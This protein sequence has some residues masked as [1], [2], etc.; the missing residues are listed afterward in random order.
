MAGLAPLVGEVLGVGR[1]RIE[2][3]TRHSVRIG[4]VIDFEINDV[5]PLDVETGR[6]VRFDGTFH[7]VA[8]DLTTA[9]SERSKF[10]AFGIQYEGETGLSAAELSRAA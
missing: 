6:P 8:S 10:D 4:D 2:V 1:A 7:P 9:E 5:V 3:G